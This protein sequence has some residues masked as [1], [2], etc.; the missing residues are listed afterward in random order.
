MDASEYKLIKG[1]FRTEREKPN[2]YTDLMKLYVSMLKHL[3]TKDLVESKQLM[4]KKDRK[5][6]EYTLNE[7]LVAEHLE[8]HKYKNK[9]MKGFHESVRE[10]F[11]KEEHTEDRVCY[12]DY[13]LD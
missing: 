4:T 5:V 10:R 6:V 13:F 3:T 1:L 7:K 9:R 8:I 2:N 11:G 12:E